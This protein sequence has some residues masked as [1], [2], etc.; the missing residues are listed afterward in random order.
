MAF[1]LGAGDV[2]LADGGSVTHFDLHGGAPGLGSVVGTLEGGGVRTWVTSAHELVAFDPH[3][4]TSHTYAIEEPLVAVD[5]GGHVVVASK[6]A[7][8]E[9]RAGKLVLRYVAQNDVSALAASSDHVWFVDG[10]ELGVVR[11]SGVSRTHAASL[12]PGTRLVGLQSGD[13]WTLDA[14]GALARWGI[15]PAVARGGRG[16]WSDVVAPI[17]SRACASCHAEG[18]PAGVDLSKEGAWKTKRDLLRQRV[19]TDHDMPPEGHALSDA[20]RAALRA[21]LDNREAQL[22]SR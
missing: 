4:H 16:A 11:E 5:S 3:A 6:R 20:D 15:G 19:L 9:A 10:N 2:A 7:V 22:P 13:V 21:W 18:G 17:F 8:Y 1:V 14:R 12:P